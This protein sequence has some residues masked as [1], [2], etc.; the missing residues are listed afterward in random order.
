MYQP[1]ECDT[2]LQNGDQWFYNAGVGIRSLSTL[3]EVYHGTVGRNGFL[4]MD[5]APDK[6]GLIAPDQV[7][8]YKEFGDYIKGCYGHPIASTTGAWEVVTWL[9]VLVCWCGVALLCVMQGCVL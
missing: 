1:S 2:T 7:A 9:R 6:D 3:V 5:F 8:R 4:M